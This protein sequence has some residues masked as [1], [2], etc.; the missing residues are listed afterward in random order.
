[1]QNS[2]RQSGDLTKILVAKEKKLVTL[3]TV[4]KKKDT[5]GYSQGSF[6]CKTLTH[7]RFKS[8]KISIIN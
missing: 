1:M 3:A 8:I 2:G 4:M 5:E 7:G 6:I